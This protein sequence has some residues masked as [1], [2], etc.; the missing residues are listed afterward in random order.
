MKFAHLIAFMKLRLALMHPSY[1]ALSMATGIVAIAGHLLGLREL[2]IGL[3]WINIFVFPILW[4]LFIARIIMFPKNVIADFSSHERAP[5]FFTVVV[6]TSVLGTQIE[7]FYK[8]QE[9]AEI[10]WWANLILWIL[11]TYS[12]FTALTVRNEK[13]SLGE[14]INGGWMI[15]VVATQSV[16]VLGCSLGATM[17]GDRDITL[18]VLMSFWLLGVMLYLWTSVLIFY[19][20]MFFPLSPRDL[21][22]PYWI[23]MGAAAITTLAG[24]LIAQAVTTSALLAQ[25][26]SF[27]L[28]LTILFW[29]TA[30]WWIPLLLILGIWKHYNRRIPIAYDPLYWGLVFPFGM[31]ARCTFQLAKAFDTTSLMW[32]AKVAVVAAASAW[33]ITFLGLSSRLLNTPL[34][35]RQRQLKQ[36][37]TNS[38]K[39]QEA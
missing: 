13:P 12:I 3:A 39:E 33:L 29:A 9:L 4:F 28:G 26:H 16:C 2:S 21:M 35:A 17:L 37:V 18:F 7:L 15:A 34:F 6:S 31:Y 10:L 30:T 20:Y 8:W 24:A 1:F 22:P 5:G 32:V 14:G 38:K 23:N 25:F 36:S 27:I 19:R 11:F